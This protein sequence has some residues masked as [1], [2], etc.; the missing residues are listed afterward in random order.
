MNILKRYQEEYKALSVKKNLE[1]KEAL[2]VV[3]QNG[4]ALQYVQTQ[5]PEIC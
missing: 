1:G 4:Y 2:E 3:K 5:T